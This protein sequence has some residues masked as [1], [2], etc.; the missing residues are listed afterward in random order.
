MLNMARIIAICGSKR[1]GKDT[2][3]SYIS[4]NHDYKP[5]K[6]A[7]KLKKVC[8]ELFDLSESQV[9]DDCK[10]VVD[11]RY[12]RTPR[13]LMQFFGTEIMQFKIQDILPNSGRLFW[14]KHLLDTTKN[15]KIVIS[16]MR[17]KHEADEVLKADPYAIIIRI[18]RDKNNV[19]DSHC[20][21]NE[22]NDIPA[23]HTIHNDSSIEDLHQK[24]RSIKLDS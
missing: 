19:T 24:I 21:E 13:E 4:Q 2:V 8:M 12:G 7:S 10:D 15:D 9:E 6:F 16:D 18:I 1:S 14:V 3:A 17:F 23:T 5:V 11:Q 22:F 20:S